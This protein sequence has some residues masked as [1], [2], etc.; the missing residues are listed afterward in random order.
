MKRKKQK[1]DEI[2]FNINKIIGATFV[3][4]ALAIASIF[5]IFNSNK[6]TEKQ[7][8]ALK[9]ANQE[10][11]KSNEN[12]EDIIQRLDRNNVDKEQKETRKIGEKFIK[13]MFINDPKKLITDKHDDATKVMTNKLA[14]KYYGKKDPMPNRYETDIKNLNIYDDRYSP[15]KENYKMFATFKQLSKE[16]DDSISMQQ[17]IVIE[18]DLKQTDDGWRVEKFKQIAGQ[19]NRSK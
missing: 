2:K 13:I 17:D 1:S 9:E 12:K 16:P 14:D 4:L 3:I 19:D 8:N 10:L 18:L 15:A 6:E 7:N 5:L 11:K